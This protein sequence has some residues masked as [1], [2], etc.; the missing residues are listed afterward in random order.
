MPAPAPLRDNGAI[1]CQPMRHLLAAAAA[2]AVL[3]PV[4]HADAAPQSSPP[5][6]QSLNANSLKLTPIEAFINKTV[7]I[8]QR[9]SGQTPFGRA[10]SQHP[11][12]GT[13][14]IKDGRIVNIKQSTLVMDGL[15][16]TSKWWDHPVTASRACKKTSGGWDNQSMCTEG[17]GSLITLPEGS[18][19]REYIYEF[20]WVENGTTIFWK[21]EITG[22]NN[23]K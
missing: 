14:E 12:W 11:S 3:M 1:C 21:T 8:K 23:V 18:D 6:S 4:F 5:S 7:V 2:A 20:K 19:F 13:F 17:V 16:G 10:L 22:V 9:L 15:F